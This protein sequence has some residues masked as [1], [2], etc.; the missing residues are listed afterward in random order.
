[1]Y[2]IFKVYTPKRLTRQQKEL[3]EELSETNLETDEIKRFNKFT[4]DND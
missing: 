3:I 4:K 2:V 1:M